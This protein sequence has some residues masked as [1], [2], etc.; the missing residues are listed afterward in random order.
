MIAI[1][2]KRQMQQLLASG[3]LGNA[4]RMWPNLEALQASGYDGLVYVRSM[5]ISN[6][7]KLFEVP[8]AEVAERLNQRRIALASCRFYEAPLNE[9]RVIQGEFCHLP[10][11]YLNYT[12]AHEPLRTA[13]ERDS[14]HAYGSEALGIL[15]HYC[16]PAD[17][18]W[19]HEL[20]DVYPGHVIEFSVLRQRVGTLRRRMVIWEVRSY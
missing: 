15:R 12:M 20:L 19:L 7:D 3:R 8:A 18:D 4:M 9:L 13:L 6:S 17:Y 16:D 5:Q 10:P 11:Y 14:R 1:T 2:N